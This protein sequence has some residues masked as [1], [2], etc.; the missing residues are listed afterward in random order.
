MFCEDDPGSQLS[1]VI[2]AE[3][4]IVVRGSHAGNAV[5]VL[6]AGNQGREVGR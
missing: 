1:D 3:G 4:A 2:L 6:L 5:A